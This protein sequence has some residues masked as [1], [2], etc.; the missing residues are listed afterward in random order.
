MIPKIMRTAPSPI[1]EQ[2][3]S[4]ITS[5]TNTTATTQQEQSTPTKLQDLTTSNN[6]KP[7]IPTVTITNG[8]AENEISQIESVL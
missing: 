7:T 6:N 1:N 2:P 3:P 4:N 5:T 8:S